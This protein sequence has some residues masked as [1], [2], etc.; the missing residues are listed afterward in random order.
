MAVMMVERCAPYWL[1]VV[2][3]AVGPG[4]VGT[5]DTCCVSMGDEWMCRAEG[6]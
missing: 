1:A 3:R 6:E 5:C 4:L 2:C